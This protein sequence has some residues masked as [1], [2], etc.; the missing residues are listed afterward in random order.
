VR[1]PKP[2]AEITDDTLTTV[3]EQ[4]SEAVADSIEAHGRDARMWRRIDAAGGGRK[5]ARKRLSEQAASAILGM[6]AI[7]AESQS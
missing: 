3:L 2:A 1:A 5:L 6:A 7:D 4:V